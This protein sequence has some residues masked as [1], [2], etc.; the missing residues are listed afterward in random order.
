MKKKKC[1]GRLM[2][3]FAMTASGT[4]NDA[5]LTSKSGNAE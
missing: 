1:A 3:I 5:M 4:L 2:I